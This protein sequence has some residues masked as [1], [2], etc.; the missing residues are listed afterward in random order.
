MQV[1]L[2]ESNVVTGFERNSAKWIEGGHCT[3]G[4]PFSVSNM[5]Y[6][7]PETPSRSGTPTVSSHVPNLVA[8]K[9]RFR[10]SFGRIWPVNS[11]CYDAAIASLPRIELAYTTANGN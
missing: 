5:L 9:N 10:S 1:Q 4:V 7:S 3:A 6:Q 11:K 8:P 2:A